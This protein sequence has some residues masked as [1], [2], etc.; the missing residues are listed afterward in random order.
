MP[1]NPLNLNKIGIKSIYD[2]YKYTTDDTLA[3]AL[4]TGYF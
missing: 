3:E 1:F 2:R 4:A